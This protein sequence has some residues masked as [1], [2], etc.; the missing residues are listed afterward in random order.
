VA[1]RLRSWRPHSRSYSAARWAVRR[2]GTAQRAGS[3][4]GI[5]VIGTVLFGTLNV[6]R[7]PDAVAA[8]F[9]HSAQVA[10]LANV[11]RRSD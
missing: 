7:G 11:G 2:L 3:A 6:R 8:A 9:S 5:A 4:I 1:S 10:L